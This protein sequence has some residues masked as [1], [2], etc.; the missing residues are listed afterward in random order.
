VSALLS[1]KAVLE[2]CH[3][4]DARFRPGHKLS[5]YLDL[6]VRLGVTKGYRVRPITVTWESNID[7][8][9]GEET[10]NLAQLQAEAVR[11]GVATPFLQLMADTPERGMHIRVSPL[12][13][14]FIQ[15]VRLSDPRH[16]RTMLGD[17]CASANAGSAQR[18][19]SDCRVISVRYRPGKRHVLRYE[20]VDPLKGD[21]VF[22]KL[23]TSESGAQA[24]RVANR[25]ADW[26]EQR[27]EGVNAA[28]PLAYVAEDGVVLYPRV[29]GT[30]L[31]HL[32]RCPREGLAGF[33][34][35]T[36]AA[37]RTLHRLPGTVVGPLE[38]RN[39][40]Y[41]IQAIERASSHIPAM[42]PRLGAA[43]DTLLDRAKELDERLPQESPTFTHR[44]FKSE[45]VWVTPSE[46][47]LIDFDRGRLADPALDVGTF[48][49]DLQW[50]HA[51]H[52]LRGMVEAQERFLVGYVPGVP[53]ERVIRA[54]LYEA[55]KLVK[56]AV[57]RVH[58]FE[59]NWAS[60]TAGLVERAKVVMADLQRV[61]GLPVRVCPRARRLHRWPSG[62]AG[63]GRR[64]ELFTF[65]S[66]AMID[67]L[68]ETTLPL[69]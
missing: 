54:R 11:L 31:S 24:F 38:V 23:Y 53:I 2:R 12:D 19:I 6:I 27:A 15:L 52:N 64:R 35:R 51:T 58:V 45:H 41:E 18:R 13:A 4:R 69:D 32:M 44:D 67:R 25:A 20:P 60:R 39:F 14:R 40:A 48:L 33:L 1:P 59:H 9:R 56:M 34:E 8:D 3:L 7:R 43:I 26:L 28:R 65:A 68:E 62:R 49:A 30:P 29:V 17:A 36:G 21:V 61:L 57:V 66:E 55:I 10:G 63:K 37:L 5:V 22:A 46:L 42:L 16:V 50:W 47:T